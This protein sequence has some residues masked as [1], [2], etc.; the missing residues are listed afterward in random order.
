MTPRLLPELLPHPGLDLGHA[1]DPAVVVLDLVAHVT[2]DLRM[3]GT[4][5]LTNRTAVPVDSLHVDVNSTMKIRRL[6]PDR[7]AVQGCRRGRESSRL[8]A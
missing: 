3:R 5:T 2:R 4:Y 1:A 7:P 8:R 6:A